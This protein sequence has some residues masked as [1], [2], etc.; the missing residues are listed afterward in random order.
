MNSGINVHR[1]A[2]RLKMAKDPKSQTASG[3]NFLLLPYVQKEI[4]ALS[5]PYQHAL[6]LF[7]TLIQPAGTSP[8]MY[9]YPDL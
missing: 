2:P 9:G 6:I 1:D 5:C 7:Y 8:L 3:I 4:I